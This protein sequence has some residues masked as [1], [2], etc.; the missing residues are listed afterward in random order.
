MQCST[1][2]SELKCLNLIPCY[3][4]KFN[5]KY[6]ALGEKKFQLGRLQKQTA[7]CKSDKRRHSHFLRGR[8]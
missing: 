8:R 5:T 7:S 3:S 2:T 1:N 6:A 4:R